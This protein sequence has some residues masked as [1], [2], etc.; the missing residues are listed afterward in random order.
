MIALDPGTTA[1]VPID[2]QNGILGRK[3]EPLFAD[4]VLDAGKAVASRF[5]AEGAPV[6]L[7]NASAALSFERA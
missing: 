1:L 7:V 2:L 6:V 4:R 5:R 3:L